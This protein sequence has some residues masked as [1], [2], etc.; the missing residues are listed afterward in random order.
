MVSSYIFLPRLLQLLFSHS[1]YFNLILRS[2]GLGS[3]LTLHHS[4]LQSYASF[5]TYKTW[6]V[7]SLSTLLFLSLTILT[8]NSFLSSKSCQ[9]KF[10]WGFNNEWNHYCLVFLLKYSRSMRLRH[11]TNKAEFKIVWVY[12]RTPNFE[13]FIPWKKYCVIITVNGCARNILQ[14]TQ[15]VDN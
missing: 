13:L 8:V 12:H 15:Y 5:S 7:S 3:S 9:K 10:L 2:S 1:K 4:F 11:R 14:I 6:T